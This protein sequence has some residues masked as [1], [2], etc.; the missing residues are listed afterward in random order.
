MLL[1]IVTD[2]H[3]DVPALEKALAEFR[4]R[5]VD[6]VV[7]LGDACDLYSAAHSRTP[8]VVALLKGAGA[9]GVWGNH[10]I[11][12]CHEVPE[13]VRERAEPEVLEYMA[14]MK[15]RLSLG[16]CHFSHVDPWADPHDPGQIWVVSDPPDTPEGRTKSFGAVTEKHSFIGHYHR[17]RVF[18]PEERIEWDANGPITLGGETRYL[19]VVGPV[20][21]GWCA[22]F[23]TDSHV[24][25]PIR[26]G[27]KG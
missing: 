27:E 5:G 4:S 14:T 19:V 26:V 16:G 17:W 18:T 3:E 22:T 9:V 13:R 11:A 1:G 23:D 24:L 20:M 12:L 6:Q 15:P 8:E 25:T 21:G 10:D 2:I 7:N